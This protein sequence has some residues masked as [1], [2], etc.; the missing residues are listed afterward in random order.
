MNGNIFDIFCSVI[1]IN[2]RELLDFI[3]YTFTVSENHVYNFGA[4]LHILYKNDEL[5]K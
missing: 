2:P 5:P 1:L 4:S 3:H